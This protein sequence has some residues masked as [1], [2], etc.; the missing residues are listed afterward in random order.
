MTWSRVVTALEHESLPITPD[1]G[2]GGLT[3]T[4]VERL[5]VLGEKRPGFCELGLNKVKLAQF[6]GVVSLGNRVLEILPKVDA[7]SGSP[8][9]CRGVLLRLLRLSGRFKGFQFKSVGQHL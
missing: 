5:A 1:G 6:C 8:E 2:D 3:P 7:G 9:E 4:E